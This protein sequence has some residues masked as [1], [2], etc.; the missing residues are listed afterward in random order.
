MLRDV[1]LHLASQEKTVSVIARGILRLNSLVE[2]GRA[3]GGHVNAIQVDYRDSVMLQA[4]LRQAVRVF[5]PISL[6]CCWIHRNAPEAPYVVAKSIIQEKMDFRYFDILG[7]TAANRRYRVFRREATLRQF[8]S[9]MYRKII[10]GVVIEN[11]VPRWLSHRE[12]S[13]GVIT[14]IK[15]DEYCHLVGE[16]PP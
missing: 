4:K 3:L 2:A 6:A 12:I 15:R 14:A 7:S 1:S 8:K 13:R 11:D 10:L 9:L 16:A 5:G